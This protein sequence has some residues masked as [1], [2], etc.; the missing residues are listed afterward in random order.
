MAGPHFSRSELLKGILKKAAR[1][2]VFRQGLLK[3][4]RTAIYDA[5]GVR[6]IDGYRVKFVEK[7]PSLDALVVLPDF[8]GSGELT[9]D[10]LGKVVGG[11][12]DDPLWTDP[13]P[14]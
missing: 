14:P 7:D 10:D 9:E 1:D 11:G 6:V 4:P 12:P 3:D 5:F 2:A 8:R 13:P